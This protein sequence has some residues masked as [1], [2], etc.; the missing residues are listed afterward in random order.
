[1]LGRV[2]IL[3]APS[4]SGKTTLAKHLLSNELFNLKFSVSS[5]TRKKREGEIEG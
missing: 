4:G 3:C 1:M 2:I 5:T